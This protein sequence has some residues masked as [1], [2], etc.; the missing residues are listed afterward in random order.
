VCCVASVQLDFPQ[1]CKSHRILNVHQNVPGVLRNVNSIISDLD[2]NIKAQVSHW[3]IS[4]LIYAGRLS[5]L[6]VQ[7][8]T[9]AA[10]LRSGEVRRLLHFV[11]GWWVQWGSKFQGSNSVIWEDLGQVFAWNNHS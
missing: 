10:A 3:P 8:Q 7:Q 11:E 6:Q 5:T 4:V 9:N 1:D 2:V